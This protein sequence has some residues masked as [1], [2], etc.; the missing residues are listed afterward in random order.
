MEYERTSP[1]ARRFLVSLV[2]IL[3]G[4]S[5]WVS[6]AGTRGENRS[7]EERMVASSAS[8]PPVVA[9]ELPHADPDPPPGEH[10]DRFQVACTTCHSTRLAFTQPPLVEKK[11]AEVVHKMTAVYGAP[12]SAEDEQAIVGYLMAVQGK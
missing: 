11:W 9:I 10:R 2:V 8:P 4:A 5:A 7:Q 1:P 12:L 3:F 6:W